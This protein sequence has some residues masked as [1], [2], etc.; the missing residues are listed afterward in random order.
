MVVFHTSTVNSVLSCVH[1]RAATATAVLE[2][3]L[4]SET[5]SRLQLTILVDDL[6]IIFPMGQ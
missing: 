3:G 5:N 6:L 4:G 2:S 1:L